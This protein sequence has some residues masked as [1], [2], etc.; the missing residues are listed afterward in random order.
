MKRLISDT[1]GVQT[2]THTYEDEAK[3]T[4]E[5][6]QDVEELIDVTKVLS[7]VSDGYNP[8]RDMKATRQIPMVLLQEIKDRTGL[9]WMKPGQW[10]AVMAE[11]DK[12]YGPNAYRMSYVNHDPHIIFKG[13]R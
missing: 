7:N 11:F 4:V 6:V 12:T 9:D 2:F 13:S 1:N 5:T 10:K 8:S 3:I